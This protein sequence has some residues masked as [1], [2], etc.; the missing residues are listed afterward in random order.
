M[1][2]KFD[3]AESKKLL[4]LSDEALRKALD[5]ANGETR[6]RVGYEG[7]SGLTQYYN[8]EKFAGRVYVGDGEVQMIYVP[9]GAALEGLTPKELKKKLK[10]SGKE[11]RSRAGKEY[12]HYVFADQGV[13]YSS[14]GDDIQII[15]VFPP[16]AHK[17]YLAEIYEDPGPFKR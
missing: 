7:L 13:A 2:A 15:E 14:D 6:E 8:P 5:I 9:A 16:R 17:A 1:T 10:G 12:T 4:G 11:L 3:L